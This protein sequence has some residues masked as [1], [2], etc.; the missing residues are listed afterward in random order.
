MSSNITSINLSGSPQQN[1]L[2]N[3][4]NLKDGQIIKAVIAGRLPD[5]GTVLSVN[6]RRLYVLT[7][8]NLPEGSRQLFQVN[9]TG[10]KIELKLLDNSIMKPGDPIATTS[11][12]AVKETLTNIITELRTALFQSGLSRIAGQEVQDLKQ[13]MSSILYSD[14]G[15]NNGTWIKENVMASGMLW[16]NK[17]MEFLYEE[18]NGSVKKLIKGDLKAILLSLQ[19]ALMKEDGDHSQAMAAKVKQALNLIEGN[20]LLNLSSLEDGLGQLF[21]IPGVEKD[22]FNKAEVFLKKRNKGKGISFSVL[23]EFTQLGRFEADVSMMES[24]V[25][26]RIL[27]DDKEKAGIVK[28]NLSALE[29]GI[30]ELGI[31]NVALSC[32]VRKATDIPGGLA[33]IYAGRSQTVNIVI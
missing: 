21:F 25:S 13:I 27:M 20:Q 32:D 23:V 16:E 5:G 18:N 6:G 17:V 4:I 12:A 22:G 24:M 1:L 8:L 31:N 14:P 2:D 29:S 33:G 3:K 11:P 9:A 7:E 10:S 19:K 28:D 15:K 26:I 30:K